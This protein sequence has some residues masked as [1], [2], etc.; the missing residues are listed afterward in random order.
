MNLTYFQPK[1]RGNVENKS[2]TS[3]IGVAS[4]GPKDPSPPNV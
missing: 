2:G 3:V 1:R 4:G